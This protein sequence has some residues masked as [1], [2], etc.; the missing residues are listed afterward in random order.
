MTSPAPARRTGRTVAA[1]AGGFLV[2]AVLSTVG[3]AVLHA[4]GVYPPLG[5]RMGDGLFGLATAYRLAFTVLGGW[6]T[7]RLA[8]SRPMWHAWV[9][10]VIG[11]VAALVGLVAT[12]NAGLGPRWYPLA[13]VVTALPCVL[14]GGWLHAR[15]AGAPAAA[16][17]Q[18]VR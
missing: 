8:P 1:V 10:G 14:L 17:G 9:L 15:G 7:A 16:G 11:T 3:D 6:V 2:T 5:E 13:L 12:W 4:T 18:P